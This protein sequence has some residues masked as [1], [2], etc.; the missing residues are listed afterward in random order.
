[1][2]THIKELAGISARITPFGVD[3]GMFN[4]RSKSGSFQA[5]QNGSAPTDG[6]V[7]T[8]GTVKKMKPEYNLTELLDAFH[9]LRQMVGG[10]PLRLLM[11][12]D[13]PERHRLEQRV[14]DMELSGCVHFTGYIP[15]SDTPAYHNM[16]DIYANVSLAES[17]GVSVLEASACGRPVVAPD[18]GGLRE[19]VRHEHTGYLVTPGNSKAAARALYRL[20]GDPRL[21]HEMGQAGRRWVRTHYSLEAST[22]KMLSIYREMT[23]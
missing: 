8:I 7:L 6:Q 20:V 22:E 9:H 15:W 19:V 3:T 4:N 17:F 12:G 2:A 14:K 1:M 5:D 16:I 10:K 18:L 21:R 23:S 13:G 11:V